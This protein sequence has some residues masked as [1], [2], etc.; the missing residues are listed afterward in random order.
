MMV[1]GEEGIKE[2]GEGIE[3]ETGEGFGRRGG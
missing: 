2:E 1:F 3:A